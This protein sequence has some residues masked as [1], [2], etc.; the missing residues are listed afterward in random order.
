MLHPFLRLGVT[1]LDV[2]LVKT[3][4]VVDA[5]NVFGLELGFSAFSLQSALLG[6]CY[7]L[8]HYVL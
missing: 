4:V 6:F 1:V 2:F 8:G 5:E 7:E 3:L